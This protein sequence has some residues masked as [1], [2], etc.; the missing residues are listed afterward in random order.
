MF[1]TRTK[2]PEE[3]SYG[4]VRKQTLRH[5]DNKDILFNRQ[6]DGPTEKYRVS[7]QY[8]KTAIILILDGI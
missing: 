6:K 2:S 5:K 7:L 4:Q 3:R 8:N 1:L